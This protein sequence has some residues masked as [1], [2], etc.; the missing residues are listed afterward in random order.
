MQHNGPRIWHHCLT[1]EIHE[2]RDKEALTFALN[3]T[4]NLR[5]WSWASQTL[6]MSN[7]LSAEYDSIK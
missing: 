7:F 6:Q 2:I 3:F 5:M 4:T 1:W